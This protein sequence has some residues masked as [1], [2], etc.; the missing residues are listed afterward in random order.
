MDFDVNWCCV[1]HL[2]IIESLLL[3]GYCI[4]V[5]VASPGSSSP[6]G[7]LGYHIHGSA[8]FEPSWPCSLLLAMRDFFF[9]LLT[10]CWLFISVSLEMFWGTVSCGV[11]VVLETLLSQ[12]TAIFFCLPFSKGVDDFGKDWDCFVLEY[13]VKFHLV[14]K[15]LL[16]QMLKAVCLLVLRK[17]LIN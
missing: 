4:L 16:L 13:L 14:L 12:S 1:S 7:L 10:L 15:V 3:N 11:T 8:Y 2:D 5:K 6:S 17:D 9:N